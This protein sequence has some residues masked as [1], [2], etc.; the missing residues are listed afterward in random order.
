VNDV[1]E[2]AAADQGEAA[3]SPEVSTP[4]VADAVAPE[5]AQPKST[6]M[7]AAMRIAQA[8]AAP[9]LAAGAVGVH[10][11]INVPDGVQHSERDQGVA[12][13]DKP[14]KPKRGRNQHTPRPAAELA[15]LWERYKDA[16]WDSEPV[17]SAWARTH[18]SLVNKAVVVARKAAFERA[19]EEPRVM[20][21]NTECRTIRCR[22]T[23][24][25]PFPHEV[26]L[27]AKTLERVESGGESIWRHYSFEPA[28]A[29]QQG[30]ARD[31]THLLVKV[32]FVSDE[33]S[34]E[35]LEIGDGQAKPATTGTVQ[36]PDEI[37]GGADEEDDPED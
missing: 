23:L 35:T 28:P 24:R 19:P 18:Q 32:S 10:W 4:P 33:V 34:Q 1:V 7:L 30:Q 21:T 12:K 20:V 37:R 14:A 31:E 13:K 27:L 22:F 9:V 15:A 2:P 36:S 26:E 17:T 25:S 6:H 5:R 8:L 16:E 11:W 29:P 3:R